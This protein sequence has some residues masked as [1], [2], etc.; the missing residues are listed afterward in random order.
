[1]DECVVSTTWPFMTVPTASTIGFKHALEQPRNLA[2]DSCLYGRTACSALDVRLSFTQADSRYAKWSSATYIYASQH[3][4]SG[5]YLDYRT[6]QTE[7]WSCLQ[8][9][10]CAHCVRCHCRA[11]CQTYF[12]HPVQHSTNESGNNLLCTNAF[13]ATFDRGAAAWAS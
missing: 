10:Q 9:V 8:S 11:W 2:L 13:A 4:E 3:S 6:K 1:M 5:L 12:D 7:E